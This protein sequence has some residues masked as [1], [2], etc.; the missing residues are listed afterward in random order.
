MLND[1]WIPKLNLELNLLYFEFEVTYVFF[2]FSLLAS[3][4]IYYRIRYTNFNH[5][6]Q[7]RFKQMKLI[8]F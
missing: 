6:S 2:L 5:E 7:K 3:D 4:A 1:L 8:T